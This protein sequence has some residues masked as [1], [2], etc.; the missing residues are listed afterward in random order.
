MAWSVSAGGMS[1]HWQRMMSSS[2]LRRTGFGEQLRER[3]LPGLPGAL[4]TVENDAKLHPHSALGTVLG[5][6]R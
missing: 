3:L 2:L 5:C 1:G 6:H 4:G